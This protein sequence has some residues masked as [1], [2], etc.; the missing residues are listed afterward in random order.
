[1]NSIVGILLDGETLEAFPQRSLSRQGCPC[2]HYYPT[3]VLEVL[4][5]STMSIRKEELKLP[6]LAH[7]MIIYWESLRESMIK[8]NET[9][10]SLW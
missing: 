4:E 8:V 5:I 1:M 9:I 3:I 6:W 7:D 10:K 2:L